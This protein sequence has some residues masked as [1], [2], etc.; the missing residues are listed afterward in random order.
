MEGWHGKSDIVFGVLL[1]VLGLVGFFGTGSTHPTALIPTWFGL[2]LGV[3]GFLAISPSESRRKLFMHINVTVGL[4]GLIGAVGS[5]L[6]GY[7]SAIAAGID[8]DY[9]ALAAK[10]TMAGLL[11]IYVNLCVRSFIQARRSRTGIV[12]GHNA[13]RWTGHGHARGALAAWAQCARRPARSAQSQA[14]L[15]KLWPEIWALVAPRKGLIAGGPRPDGHQPRRRPGA[16]LTAQAAA[17]QG[18][19]AASIRIL[20]C[21]LASLLWCFRRMVVQAITSFSL[22]QLLSKAGQ[23]LIAEMRRQVQRHVGLLSVAYYDENRTGT[24]VARIMTDVEGVRNL[25]GT[26]LVEFVGG[27]LTAVLVFLLSAAPE[28]DGHADG[29][30]GAGRIRLHSAVRL[31]DHSPHL[32]RARQDQRRSHRPA[33]GVAGRRAR[34]QGLSRRGARGAASSPAAW[35]GCCR[36]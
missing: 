10:L 24:L 20:S 35:S 36:T 28:R 19:L 3:G 7:G 23:R 6:H 2:A 16:A 13:R 17:R 14:N 26:G 8:P 31:Q 21:C 18:A 34:H 30:L 29:L 27:M 4:L 15:K 32:S 1:I 12:H 33:D 9:I 25:V 22:T 5:A 11:L